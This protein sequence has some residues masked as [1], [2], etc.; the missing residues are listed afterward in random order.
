MNNLFVLIKGEFQRLMKYNIIQVGLGVSVLWVL[1]LFLLGD[2]ADDFVALF[3]F[4][5]AALMT[6]LLIGAGL[7]Y[8][9]QENTIKTLL[10][11]PAALWHVVMS[12]LLSAVYIA[13]QSTVLIGLIAFFFFDVAVNFGWLIPFA[14]VIGVTHAML[15]YA[16]S[17][18]TEDFTSLIALL[19]LYMIIFAFPTIFYALNLLSDAWETI[20]IFSP[21]HASF[22]LIEYSLGEEVRTLWLVIS[23]VYMVVLSILISVFLVYP[24]YLEKA[25]RE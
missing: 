21:T 1:V 19:M 11:T 16:F 24:K 3:I 12:K 8:E 7:Y 6:V 5:D 9:R 22:L 4:M 14:V 18:L 20:L 15:G 13:L 10:I 25:V 17:I 2:D 23:P